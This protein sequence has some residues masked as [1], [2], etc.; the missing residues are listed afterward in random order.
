MRK[1]VFLLTVLCLGAISTSAQIAMW[2]Y[3]SDCKQALPCGDMAW[4]AQGKSDKWLMINM[5]NGQPFSAQ[6]D[7]ISPFKDGFALAMNSEDGRWRVAAVI[8]LAKLEE[9]TIG[10]TIYATGTT[11]FSEGFACVEVDKDK[12][13]FMDTNGNIDNATYSEVH[14]FKDGRAWVVKKDKKGRAD[15][16]YI[17]KKGKKIKNAV[18]RDEDKVISETS[19]IVAIVPD[20]EYD[21]FSDKKLYGYKKEGK[22]VT[23]A[24]FDFTTPYYNNIACARKGNVAGFVMMFP[25]TIKTEL[26]KAKGKAET[27]VVTLP[28]GYNAS[29]LELTATKKDGLTKILNAEADS[30]GNSNTVSFPLKDLGNQFDL[31]LAYGGVVQAIENVSTGQAPTA[32]QPQADNSGNVTIVSFNKTKDRADEKDR[33]YIAVQ[34]KNSSAIKQTVTAT[35]YVDGKALSPVKVTVQPRKNATATAVINGVV[36]ERMAKVY[37][38]LSNGQKSAVKEIMIKPFY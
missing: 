10:K 31:L 26:K 32:Q 7:S 34:L 8:S 23:P 21:V 3:Y 30:T 24:Q 17:D 9:K 27:Y 35:V 16:F 12:Q 4:K 22:I 6:Y 37:V 38:R 28:E 33:Q 2:K 36:K 19:A 5:E 18:S 11:Y 20:K 25:G 1:T 15:S 13:A 14:P 29:L